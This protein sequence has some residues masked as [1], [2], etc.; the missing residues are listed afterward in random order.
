MEDEQLQVRRKLD[1]YWKNHPEGYC[2]EKHGTTS[3]QKKRRAVMN[4]RAAASCLLTLWASALLD[5]IRDNSASSFNL[6]LPYGA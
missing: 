3:S 2:V 6:L 4:T 5:T 1:E